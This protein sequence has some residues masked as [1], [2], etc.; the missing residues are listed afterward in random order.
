MT[1]TMDMWLNI[2]CGFI[3]P[4]LFGGI[5]LA[6]KSPLVLLLI[7]PA[8]SIIS[9]LINA[10]GFHL[11]FWDFT[12][13]IPNDESISALPLDIG[14]YPLLACFMIRTIIQKR[15]KT[16]LVF[17]LFVFSTTVLEYIG[18][19]IGKVSY[20]HGWNVGFTFLSYCVGFGTVFLYFKLLERHQVL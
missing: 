19:I 14:M 5:Y 3:V 11:K 1:E 17:F 9:S 20:G 2:I 15:K 10:L 12:P 4:W 7:F 18:T 8:G 13:L 16:A 6:R